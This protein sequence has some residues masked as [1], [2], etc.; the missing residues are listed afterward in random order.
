MMKKDDY[1]AFPDIDKYARLENLSKA[2]LAQAFQLEQKYHRL[3]LNQKDA[4]KRATLYDQFYSE[5]IPLY[6]RNT[7]IIDGKNPKDKY[8]NLFKKELEG[9]SIVDYGC[10]QGQMLKSI[11]R[12]LQVNKL[13]GIDIVIPNELKGHDDIEFIESNIMQHT[14]EEQ[15]DVAVSDNVLEHLVK[16][17]ALLHLGSIFSNLKSRGKLIIIMPNRLFGPWDVTRIKDFSQ[18][19]R[20]PAEGGHVNESTH[21]E[22]VDQLKA[23]GFKEFST[24]L[25]IPKLKYLFFRNIRINT[26]WIERIEQSPRLLRL[27]KTLRFKGVCLLKFPVIIVA[28]K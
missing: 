18:S 24:I 12:K 9:S 13:T 27:L 6:N 20:L 17:D 22:M 19:G 5:L 8:V 25:P 1:S 15:F 21:T 14:F 3:L 28:K 26:T 7:S 16:E 23:I 2:I 11:A 4:Q 10:G